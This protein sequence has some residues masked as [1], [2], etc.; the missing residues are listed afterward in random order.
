MSLGEK[1]IK[2][3]KTATT[4]FDK[5][6]ARVT[7]I[8]SCWRGE[9]SHDIYCGM[10]MLSESVHNLTI[11]SLDPKKSRKEEGNSI[12]MLPKHM[13]KES[14]WKSGLDYFIKNNSFGCDI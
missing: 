14:D 11:L 1:E 12:N 5:M 4:V 9:K 8:T 6:A 7:A 13:L 3:W 2:F 10:R